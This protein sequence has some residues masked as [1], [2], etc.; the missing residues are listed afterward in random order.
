LKLQVEN[1]GLK[2]VSSGTRLH[3]W[4]Y[5]PQNFKAASNYKIQNY[6]TDSN[7]QLVDNF[8]LVGNCGLFET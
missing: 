7:F 4:N 2:F 5:G 8:E 1:W 3:T 6:G